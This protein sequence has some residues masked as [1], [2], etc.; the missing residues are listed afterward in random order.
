[1]SNSTLPPLTAG[2]AVRVILP[3]PNY[4]RTGRV[5]M[6]D[7]ALMVTMDDGGGVAGLIRADLEPIDEIDAV[8]FFD[9][10][11]HFDGI[12]LDGHSAYFPVLGFE[13]GRDGRPIA[14]L[15]PATVDALGE[16]IARLA[17]ESTDGDAR[18]Y[19]DLG[20]EEFTAADGVRHYA[21]V[22]D[23]SYPLGWSPVRFGL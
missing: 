6:G 1:M 7:N 17:D 18:S 20:L 10:S 4:G 3:G 21:A 5:A 19:L 22:L 2:Q 23:S 14:F 13:Q 12:T 15:S 16:T 8:E 11:A 9:Y